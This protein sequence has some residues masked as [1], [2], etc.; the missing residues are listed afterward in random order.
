LNVANFADLYD[1]AEGYVHSGDTVWD[2]G[3]NMG[4][5]SLSAAARAGQS[6]RV[7]CI[8]PD[9]WSAG[10]LHHTRRLNSGICA[11]L[12]VLQVAISDINGIAWLNIPERGRAAASIDIRSGGAGQ[13]MTGGVRERHLVPTV[14]L[15]WLAT[16]YPT[17]NVLKVDVDGSELRVFQGATALLREHHPAILTEVYERNADA[18]T[19]L[20]HDA[21]YVLYDF[22]HGRSSISPIGRATYNTLALP[23]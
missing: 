12:D 3:A 19:S 4:V 6:G 23:P 1:F 14:S 17:P 16:H 22:S 7:L 21:G 5:F 15:D 10:L 2:I 13:D 9:Y 8:E 18:V 20:L 11:P